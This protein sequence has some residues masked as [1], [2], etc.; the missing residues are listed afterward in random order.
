[1][2]LPIKRKKKFKIIYAAA[3]ELNCL[4]CPL[5]AILPTFFGV[6]LFFVILSVSLFNESSR[7]LSS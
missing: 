1:M 4:A 6:F 7:L 5:G 3:P 2:F